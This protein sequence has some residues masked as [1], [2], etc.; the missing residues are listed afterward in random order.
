MAYKYESP[1][2][3]GYT[4]VS[5]SRRLHNKILPNRNLSVFDKA[6]YYIN[7]EMLIIH[8]MTSLFGKAIAVLLFPINGLTQGFFN[9]QLYKEY[10]HLFF[11]K[12]YGKFGADILVKSHNDS[13]KFIW[14]VVNEA[15]E[16]K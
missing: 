12:K 15:K 13:S 1:E 10:K 14:N 7:D 11:E 4:K 8:R 2:A 9:K 6:E 5:V 16:K 3:R